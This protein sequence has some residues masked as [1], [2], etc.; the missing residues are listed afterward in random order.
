MLSALAAAP[1][2]ASAQAPAATAAPTLEAR[3]ERLAAE[4]ERN[5]IDQHAPGAAVAVVR[6]GKV[7]FARGF[8]LA[9]VADKTPVTPETRFFIGS[10]TKA[11]TAT[12][13]RDA[14]GRGQ[15]ALG[16]S[17]RPAPAVFQAGRQQATIPPL[18]RPCVTSSAIEP[19]FRA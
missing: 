19:A 7:I 9:N 11:F 14:G 2:P 3:L 17:G 16:R 13:D 12:I 1:I 15:D 5:R 8:G 4:L 10:T 18:A 6:E